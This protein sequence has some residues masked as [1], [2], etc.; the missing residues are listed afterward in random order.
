VA[1]VIRKVGV[2]GCGTMGSGIAEIVARNG[3]EVSFVE[4]DDAAVDRGRARI[5]ASLD[6][7]VSRGRLTEEER[8]A[9]LGRIR[10]GTDFAVLAEADLIVEAV[11][12][13]LP[14]KQAAF[15]NIDKVVRED[16]IIATNTSSLPVMD[17]AVH[18]SRPNRVLGF[19]FFN[20]APV[21]KLIE[22]VRTVV[23]DESVVATAKAFA[24]Q[25]GKSPVVVGDRRGFIA[26]QLL[27]PYLNQAIEMVEGGYATKEDIDAAMRFGAGLPMGP[28]A[29]VDLVGLDTMIGIMEA[30]HSQFQDTRF[31]PRPILK[32]LVAAG[33]KGRKSGRGFY[34]YE[35]P[36]SSQVV[37]EEGAR[38]APDESTIAGWTTIGVLGTGTMATGI[39]EV[40]AKAGYDVVVRGRS[41]E[42]AEAVAAAVSKSMQKMVEKGRMSEEDMVAALARI[43]PTHDIADMADCDLVIEAVAEDLEIKK[44]LFAELAETLKTGAILSTATSSLPVIECAMVTDRPDQVVGLHFF[45]PAA[46][47]KLVEIVP[48][49][50]TDD[51][52]V[53]QARAF[54]AKVGKVGVLCPDRAGFIV[55]AL[56]FPY[57]NDAVKMLASHYA[58]SEEIDTA[59]KLGAGYPMGPFQLADIVGLDVAL[60]IIETLHREFR[61]PSFAPA[62]LLRHLVEAEFL[63]RKAGRGFYTY[64]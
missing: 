48:T 53:E 6:R 44:P 54:V 30:I 1:E 12:E 41:K 22:L 31:A 60:A 56:L 40:C 45:N 21:M 5:E 64:S 55:N 23:T 8:D 25:I 24:E 37:E 34:T 63:G 39:T 59:M 14:L 47:M 15:E 4:I 18:A 49:V 3:I 52:V 26:N 20:P 29:L 13:Q 16:A 38:P 61:E 27:F 51:A 57:I 58:T 11:P 46:I 33:Y 32:Q 19:H 17:I 43:K 10:G 9:I 28:L 50:R 62:P 36:G 42:K 35:A 7:Q 2:V